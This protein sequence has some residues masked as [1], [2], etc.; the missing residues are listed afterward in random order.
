M[1]SAVW[2]SMGRYRAS[3]IV[4]TI[5]REE[6]KLNSPADQIRLEMDTPQKSPAARFSDIFGV[7]GSA[8]LCAD[9]STQ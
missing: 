1:K 6:V 3:N 9:W 4:I 8:V 2:D 7:E 5:F